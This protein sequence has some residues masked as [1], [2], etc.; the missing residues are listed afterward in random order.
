MLNFR[1]I[2]LLIMLSSATAAFA[3]QNVVIL[4]DDSGSMDQPM[5]SNSN[6]LKMDAA[7]S[8]IGTV[9]QQLP[10]D[11]NVGLAVLNGRSGPWVIPFGPLDKARVSESVSRIRASGGTPLGANMKTAADALLDARSNQYYGT[12]KL[13]IITDGEASDPQLVEQYLPEILARGI[14]MDVIGVDMVG[15]HSLA[16]R[17]SSYRKADDP[18][19]LTRAISEVMAETSADAGDAGTSDFELLEGFPTEAAT[20]ALQA[21]ANPSN[22][23]VGG[24]QP[25]NGNV[26]S[27]YPGNSSPQQGSSPNAGNND[28][29]GNP[30]GIMLLLLVGIPLFIFF[31]VAKSQSRRR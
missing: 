2:V 1:P 15:E 5:R 18:E 4:L 16:T 24:L 14:V 31:R 23:P 21:L 30:F 10:S 25:A 12:Y 27:N 8:A 29:G 17:T 28:G 26:Q 19:S 22:E 3:Q 9:L 7:K 13:L 6:L 11:A 20:V